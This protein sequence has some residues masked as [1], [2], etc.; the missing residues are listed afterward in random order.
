[1][2]YLSHCFPQ[3]NHIPTAYWS[4]MLHCHKFW[5]LIMRIKVYLIIHDNNIPIPTMQFW[6]LIPRNIF[7]Q[8][9]MLYTYMSTIVWVDMGIPIYCIVGYY[10]TDASLYIMVFSYSLLWFRVVQRY[11]MMGQLCISFYNNLFS[12]SIAFAQF[13]YDTSGE[14]AKWNVP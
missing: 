10:L 2:V 6:V 4:F 1:M 9:M 11:I 5:M 12:H 8:K 14:E 7:C 13:F 3:H